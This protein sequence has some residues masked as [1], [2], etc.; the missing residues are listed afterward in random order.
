MAFRLMD[1]CQLLH[2]L[3]RCSLSSR[4]YNGDKNINYIG[5]PDFVI[6]YVIY[7]LITLYI[8]FPYQR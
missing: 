5:S 2:A 1:Y 3:G 8:A 7:I 6:A 4:V